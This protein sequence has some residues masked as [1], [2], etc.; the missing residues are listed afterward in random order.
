MALTIHPPQTEISIAVDML[1]Q[2]V[3]DNLARTIP[4]PTNLP[5]HYSVRRVVSADQ[6]VV[7][8]NGYGKP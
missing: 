5:K 8:A 3:G 2:P 6:K 1:V 7:N 4:I